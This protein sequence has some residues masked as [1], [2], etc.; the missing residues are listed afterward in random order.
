L[1]FRLIDPPR[2][3]LSPNVTS[4]DAKCR[5]WKDGLKP[6][7]RSKDRNGADGTKFRT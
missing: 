4:P 2:L 5:D 1:S 6:L 3:V 7:P